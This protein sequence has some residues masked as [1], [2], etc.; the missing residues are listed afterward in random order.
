M[1]DEHSE[2]MDKIEKKQEEIMGQLSKILELIS[3]DKGKKVA[4][5]FGTPE[6]IGRAHV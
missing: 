1:G 6:E 4:G 2:R 3:T 5:S